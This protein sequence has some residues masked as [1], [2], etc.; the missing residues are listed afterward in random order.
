MAEEVSRADDRGSA[1]SSREPR[2]QPPD[3]RSLAMIS[4]SSIR[5]QEG[6]TVTRG[7]APF[8]KRQKEIARKDKQQRKVERR[9]QRKLDNADSDNGPIGGVESSSELEGKPPSEADT[10]QPISET[11][12]L[13]SDSQ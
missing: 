8:Q 13:N 12:R 2:W 7:K 11:Q 6:L 1:R 4:R 5:S 9:A 3:D 10:T